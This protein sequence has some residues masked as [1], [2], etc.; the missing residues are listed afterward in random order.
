V[1]DDS[2][3]EKTTNVADD[4]IASDLQNDL[5]EAE[6]VTVKEPETNTEAPSSES[7]N[8]SKKGPSI[9]VHKNH[10]MDLI[11]GNPDH[12]ITTRRA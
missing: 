12:G 5:Q 9:G 4:A 11:I 1:I 10:P 2:A 6:H 3:D 7:N 8:A